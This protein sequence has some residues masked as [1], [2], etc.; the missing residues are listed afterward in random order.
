MKWP[1]RQVKR[2][3]RGAVKRTA[4]GYGRHSTHEVRVL[5]G[6]SA[7]L[8]N[9]PVTVPRAVLRPPHRL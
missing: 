8:H 7:M 2:F 6:P 4:F 5:A 1:V 3:G 9:G